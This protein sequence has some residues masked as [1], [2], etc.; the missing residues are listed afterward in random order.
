VDRLRFRQTKAIGYIL[1]TPK[2]HGIAG[3]YWQFGSDAKILV[4]SSTA[5]NKRIDTPVTRAASMSS[6]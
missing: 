5:P 3:Q 4:V 1:I 6:A 2:V